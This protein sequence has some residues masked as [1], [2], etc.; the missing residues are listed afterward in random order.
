MKESSTGSSTVTEGA[1]DQDSGLG[2]GQCSS[3]PEQAQPRQV[4]TAC[5]WKVSAAAATPWGC[6]LFALGALASRGLATAMGSHMDK[7]LWLGRDAE[8]DLQM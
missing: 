1:A 3:S 4:A 5:P 6:L 2:V 8:K 7:A